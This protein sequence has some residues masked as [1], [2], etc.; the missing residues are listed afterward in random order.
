MTTSRRETIL[1][2][3]QAALD[4]HMPPGAVFERNTSLS[5]RIP[6]SGLVILRD[7]DP[8]EPAVTFSPLAYHYEHRAEVDLL[9]ENAPGERDA[10]FDALSRALGAAVAAD[11][12]LGGLIDWA[13]AEAPAPL[14]L[15]AEGAE[16]IKAAT[17][18][19]VLHYVTSE[20]L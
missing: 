1:L 19:V 12:T 4:A 13:E 3:L 14:H 5:S 16:S 18:A 17:V 15:V 2:A 8:G 10:T 6:A 11:R 20:T 9:V 7:G